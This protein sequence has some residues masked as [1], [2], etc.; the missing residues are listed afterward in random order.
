MGVSGRDLPR[1]IITELLHPGDVIITA[2]L[3]RA[4]VVAIDSRDPKT[5]K[6][7]EC[8]TADGLT[9]RFAASPSLVVTRLSAGKGVAA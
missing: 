1:Q 8:L 6:W 9:L 5:G 3:V 2:D 4:T 7:V